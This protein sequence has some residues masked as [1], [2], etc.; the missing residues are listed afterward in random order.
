MAGTP[1]PNAPFFRVIWPQT[2]KNAASD[3]LVAV[4]STQQSVASCGTAVP[5]AVAQNWATWYG[6]TKAFL[7]SDFG[8]WGL[9]STMD[10]IAT[11]AAEL[12]GPGGW[13][14]LLSGFCT[15]DAPQVDPTALSSKE[16]WWMTGLQWSV[17]AVVAVAGAYVV[18]EVVAVIPMAEPR[19]PRAPAAPRLS[20][21]LAARR[22]RA[23]A[24]LAP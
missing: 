2:A 5:A 13:Q 21:T 14:E 24:H 17:V 11:Y 7:T 9:G 4:E 10:Q 1:P 12:S 22:A 23:R 3:L 16:K 6:N 18:G 8:I 15:V 19:A 20:P